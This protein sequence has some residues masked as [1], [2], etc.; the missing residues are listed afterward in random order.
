METP[1]LSLHGNTRNDLI[2]QCCDT[3]E[4]LKTAQTS[5]MRNDLFNGRNA[6]DIEHL[7]KLQAMR[8]K[9]V[10]QIDEIVKSFEY[11]TENL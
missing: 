3:I 10:L 7:E 8:Q 6:R 11:V 2:D 5:V 4:A 1:I 9:F